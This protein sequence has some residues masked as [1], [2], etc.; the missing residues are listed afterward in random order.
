M[1]VDE[2][3]QWV[4]ADER[5]IFLKDFYTPC[6]P[7]VVWFCCEAPLKVHAVARAVCL[8]THYQLIPSLICVFFLQTL[9][10]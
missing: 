7:H 6:E 2:P 1:M 10:C 4:S 5:L 8:G 9:A 3:P